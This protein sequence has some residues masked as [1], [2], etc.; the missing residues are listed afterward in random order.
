MTAAD[1]ACEKRPS[2]LGPMARFGGVGA[3]ARDFGD[4]FL[5]GDQRSLQAECT[6]APQL[7]GGRRVRLLISCKEVKPRVT[8]RGTAAKNLSAR[9][10]Y[11]AKVRNSCAELDAIERILAERT[12]KVWPHF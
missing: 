5:E 4:E 12:V 10:S 8:G 7:A 2:G 3:K 9:R 1:R 6:D 11:W